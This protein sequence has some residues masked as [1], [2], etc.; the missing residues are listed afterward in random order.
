MERNILALLRLFQDHVPDRETHSWVVKLA[1]DRARWQQG[2]DVFDRIRHR[3]LRAIRDND[4]TKQAQYCFEETC[5]KSLYN[6]TAT[7]APFD[8]DAPYSIIP[9]AIDLAR[10]VGIRD[11]EVV[12]TVAP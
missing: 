8:H 1:A 12:R 5:L 10:R 4:E 11:E 6:E 7:D 9:T 2:H 3:N